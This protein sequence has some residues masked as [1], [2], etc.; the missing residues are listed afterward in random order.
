M[1]KR[2]CVVG[3]TQK[4]CNPVIAKS[5]VCYALQSRLCDIGIDESRCLVFYEFSFTFEDV[6]EWF[7]VSNMLVVIK[8]AREFYD[9]FPKNLFCVDGW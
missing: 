5:V 7:L 2:S 9:G 4:V 3:D 8:R 6:L 1:I